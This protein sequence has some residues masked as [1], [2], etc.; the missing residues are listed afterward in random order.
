MSV[1][2][3]L[4]DALHRIR[5]RRNAAAGVVRSAL[6]QAE[7]EL[8]RSPDRRAIHEIETLRR[9]M[10]ILVEPSPGPKLTGVDAELDRSLKEYRQLE[11]ELDLAK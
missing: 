5:T 9:A 11:H 3:P 7:R 1:A 4:E 6:G 8:G 2:K 10:A